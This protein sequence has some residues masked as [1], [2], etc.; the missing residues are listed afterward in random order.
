MPTSRMRDMSRRWALSNQQ[1]VAMLHRSARNSDTIASGTEKLIPFET[2]AKQK[3]EA[4]ANRPLKNLSTPALL[5]S[6]MLSQVFARPRIASIGMKVMNRIAKSKQ[7]LLDPDRNW[8]LNRLLRA[9][10]YDQF[11]GGWQR[12]QIA[13][14]LD[15]VKRCGYAGVILQYAREVVAHDLANSSPEVDISAQQITQW[16]EGNLRTLSMVGPGDYMAVK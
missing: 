11:C 1:Q 8:L 3:H 12:N 14:T 16:H 9:T 13:G 7:P 4:T 15:A 10:V 6:I 5:R 2:S